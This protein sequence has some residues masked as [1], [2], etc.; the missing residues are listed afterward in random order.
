M[1]DLKIMN[2]K[3]YSII[4]V[5][6]V[7]MFSISAITIY[8]NNSTP[9]VVK[10]MDT[11]VP[12]DIPSAP[13]LRLGDYGETV[14]Q[15]EAETISPRDIAKF[16]DTSKVSGLTESIQLLKVKILDDDYVYYLYAT[17]NTP[18]DDKVSLVEFIENGGIV[19]HTYPMNNPAAFYEKH[20]DR[21]DASY[22]TVNN[23]D[24][25]TYQRIDVNDQKPTN[26]YIYPG[27]ERAILIMADGSSEK[28][29][30]LAKQL[31]IKSGTLDLNKYP[32]IPYSPEVPFKE[33]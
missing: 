5:V 18:V 30:N 16:S 20:L 27:D 8:E 6:A 31:D 29:M 11:A 10:S 23:M 9:L 25:I 24:A 3:Q 14:T 15:N 1:M 28:V 2:T 22:R 13:T 21:T 7:A 26:V 17:Q 32:L 33:Q 4:A 19:V 12:S